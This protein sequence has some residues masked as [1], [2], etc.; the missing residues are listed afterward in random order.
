MGEV[1][2]KMRCFCLY[3]TVLLLSNIS[4][5]DVTPAG[6]V[7]TTTASVSYSASDGRAIGT[8]YSAPTAVQIIQLVGMTGNSTK[9]GDSASPDSV[10]VFPFKITNLGNGFDRFLFS[11][12]PVAPGWSAYVTT[13]H[14]GDGLLQADE[15]HTMTVSEWTDQ[16]K[17]FNG[18]LVLRVPSSNVVTDGT[19]ITL[20][21]VSERNSSLRWQTTVVAGRSDLIWPKLWVNSSEPISCGLA[22]STSSEVI[23]TTDRGSVKVYGVSGSTASEKWKVSI[24]G[25]RFVCQPTVRQGY[26]AAVTSDMRLAFFDMV[27]RKLTRFWNVS[28][29]FNLA[30]NPIFV[31]SKV[32]M[33]VN[34]SRLASIDPT[35]NV[36]TTSNPLN[37]AEITTP[38]AVSGN[39]LYAGCADGSLLAVNLNTMLLSWRTVL[40]SRTKLVAAPVIDSKNGLVLAATSTG[41]VYCISSTSRTVRWKVKT[42]S[43]IASTL[44]VDA[45]MPNVYFLTKDRRLWGFNRSTGQAVLGYPVNIPGT[46]ELNSQA[47]AVKRS[48]DINATPYIWFG[49]TDSQLF[50]INANNGYTSY[51]WLPKP[52]SPYNLTPI[53]ASDPIS[54][55]MAIVEGRGTVLWFE[56]K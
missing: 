30:T 25:V 28:S 13:D 35:T 39:I 8:E 38:L 29:G 40:E 14:N 3:L 44:S 20:T 5:A 52:T 7:L 22:A 33:G 42:N 15:Q 10:A 4:F 47:L 32:I 23:A 51:Q 24:G 11:L 12:T 45:K 36:I 31:G 56:I 46:G 21:A 41:T 1:V 6:S 27:N 49:T 53:G 34:G 17:D 43:Q 19:Q 2:C 9:N 54:N 48:N 26:L 18:L 37:T 16:N 55:T 50:A